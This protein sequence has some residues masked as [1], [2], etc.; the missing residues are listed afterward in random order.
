MMISR[1]FSSLKSFSQAI[2][3]SLLSVPLHWYI[4]KYLPSV[5]SS[6]HNPHF[7][8]FYPKYSFPSSADLNF[9]LSEIKHKNGVFASNVSTV[10]RVK[11][12]I[13]P[14]QKHPRRFWKFHYPNSNRNRYIGDLMKY[15]LRSGRFLNHCLISTDYLWTTYKLIQ[16]FQLKI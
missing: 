13:S 1:Y 2:N 10:V 5:I 3:T 9:W 4:V 8:N 7:F 16:L 11:I 12:P 6:P 14:L 15:H